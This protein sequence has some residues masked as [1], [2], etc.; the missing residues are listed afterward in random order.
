MEQTQQTETKL[1][2]PV[3]DKVK[4]PR[5]AYMVEVLIDSIPALQVIPGGTLVQQGEWMYHV[6]ATDLPIIEGMA[7]TDEEKQL[8]ELSKEVFARELAQ[9]MDDDPL[10]QE[11]RR[12]GDAPE[13]AK[14]E[15]ELGDTWPGS[16]Q[17][18]FQRDY[19]RPLHP[20][21]SV[22]VLKRDLTNP[23]DVERAAAEVHRAALERAART[24]EVTATGAAV[25]AAV[26]L[27]LAPLVQALQQPKKGG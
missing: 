8:F 2:K 27:A 11:F 15:R 16:P 12:T 5:G 18:C 13:L 22:K 6:L 3:T 26:A 4:Y 20:F 21:R 25:A 19:R 9:H 23:A 17:G 14:R 24:D 7:S 10:V 1:V